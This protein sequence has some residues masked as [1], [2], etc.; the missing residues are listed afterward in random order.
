MSTLHDFTKCPGLP[1]TVFEKQ[2]FKINKK[3]AKKY[4]EKWDDTDYH[5]DNVH[6]NSNNMT[7]YMCRVK[8]VLW[9]TEK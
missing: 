4:K 7:K 3:L 2:R 5:A 8:R 1:K 9:G 6:L